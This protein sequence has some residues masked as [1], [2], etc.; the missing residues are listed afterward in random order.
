VQPAE[1]AVR[2]RHLLQERYTYAS[3]PLP[4]LLLLRNSGSTLGVGVGL[5]RVLGGRGVLRLR[6][7]H[8]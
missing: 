4:V 2:E 6:L 7:G 3:D 5:C 8:R 1:S